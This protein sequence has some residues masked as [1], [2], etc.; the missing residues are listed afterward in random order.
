MLFISIKNEEPIW[1][2]GVVI[3]DGAVGKVRISS[4]VYGISRHL[5]T[6]LDMPSN[7]VRH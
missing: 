6:H 3:G 5:N 7:L 1:R 2:L 4:I